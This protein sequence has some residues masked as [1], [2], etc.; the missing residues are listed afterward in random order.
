MPELTAEVAQ[1]LLVEYGYTVKKKLGQGGCGAAFQ[2]DDRT[3]AAKAM[4]FC[5]D[6]EVSRGLL[7]FEHDLM[8][9]YRHP[10]LATVYAIYL[11]S[12]YYAFELEFYIG[13]DLFNKI[14]N[15]CKIDGRPYQPKLLTFSALEMAVMFQELLSAIT[16]L[17][18][19]FV[20]HR[21]IKPPNILFTAPD[22][23]HM[24]IGTAVLSDLGI[25]SWKEL[26]ELEQQ[27]LRSL[28]GSK[29][30]MCE[31]TSGVGTPGY[32]APEVLAPKASYGTSVD[33]WSFGKVVQAV[34]TGQVHAPG[35]IPKIIHI[36]WLT[37]LEHNC[38]HSD[39]NARATA[40]DSVQ[41]MTHIVEKELRGGNE[42]SAADSSGSGISYAIR[43]TGDGLSLAKGRKAEK[44][45][46]GVAK[47]A[48]AASAAASGSADGGA[49]SSTADAAGAVYPRD[50]KPW[51]IQGGI[52]A[53][54][55]PPGSPPP[56]AAPADPPPATEAELTA[57]K[58]A[59]NKNRKTR[60]AAKKM[61]QQDQEEESSSDSFIV[62]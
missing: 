25:A 52:W 23:V 54:A 10:H 12:P 16:F 39:A 34:T 6:D 44:L 48:K 43:R 22:R 45:L 47:V 50:P 31:R 20:V 59:R 53:K 46:K 57:A 58:K 35:K 42:P 56:P 55:G 33:M 8:Q 2:I 14:V 36:E 60:R 24:G 17:H 32:T 26:S 19:V 38:C 5:M 9:K 62:V 29:V 7:Q 37:T 1:D 40:K 30:L 28:P 18:S 15:R 21:D 13:G 11:I 41:F 49:S 4:K 27:R 61:L 51:T 3:G